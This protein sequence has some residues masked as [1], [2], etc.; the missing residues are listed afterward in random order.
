M[1]LSAIIRDYVDLKVEGE[2]LDREWSSINS[3]RQRRDDYRER[4]EGLEKA[5]DAAILASTS[6]TQKGGDA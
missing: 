3:N 1:K 4:L 2:P 5:I 6:S